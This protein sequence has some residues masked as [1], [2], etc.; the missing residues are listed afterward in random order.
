MTSHEGS[1]IARLRE[2]VGHG[3]VVSPGAQVLA[4]R[5]DGHVLLQRRTDSGVWEIPA[6]ACEPGQSF[7]DTA[8]N[9]FRE[10]VGIQ[11]APADLV[12]FATLSDPDIHTLHYPNG[13]AV[14]AFALCFTLALEVSDAVGS[15]TDG[16]AIAWDWFNPNQPPSRSTVRPGRY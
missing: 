6:G 16:E 8:I 1:Y 7:L 9:E 11:I 5:G 3:L 14:H 10:E 12:P 2:V 15:R 13:D 4:V